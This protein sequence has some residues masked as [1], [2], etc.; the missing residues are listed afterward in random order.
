MKALGADTVIDY[1][2]ED[3]TRNGET[4]NVIFDAVRKL[5]DSRSRRSLTPQGVFLS[6][7]SSTSEQPENLMFLKKLIEQ[8]QIK[9]VIDRCYP[10]ER[11]V[12]A[13]RYV[14]KG[15]KKGNVSITVAD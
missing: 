1:T 7:K 12:E 6:V 11:I 9:A 2:Q 4:Y 13:H 5:S 14:D 10:L 3:F 8:G 15:H